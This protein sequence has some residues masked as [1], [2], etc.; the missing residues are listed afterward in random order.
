MLGSYGRGRDQVGELLRPHGAPPAGGWPVVVL[1]HGGFWRQRYDR[2]LMTPLAEA[3]QRDGFA[4]W[5]LE[6]RRVGGEGGW[7]TTLED[8]AA[9]I[10]HLAGLTDIDLQRVAVVGHS[11]GGHLALWAASR[12]RLPAEAPGAGPD[13]VP[14]AAVGL[15]P[16]ADL[17]GAALAGLG[18]GAVTSFLG[19]SQ[20]RFPRR[21]RWADPIRLVGHGVPVLLVHGSEDEDVPPEQSA[22]YHDA[23]RSAGDEV[24]VVTQ[25]IGH[26]DVIDPGS[27]AWAE[28]SRW[29]ASRLE[30]APG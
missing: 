17:E 22:A 5:N 23:A 10:D 3:L 27:P 19:G 2:T 14:A 18:D 28:T 24:S 21:W 13:L 25:P 6:Y 9:G 11:A 7:P 15:A 30:R 12:H 20:R 4:S 8:V 1:V 16:V 29:L 26:R